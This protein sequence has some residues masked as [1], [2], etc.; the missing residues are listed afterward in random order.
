MTKIGLEEREAGRGGRPRAGKDPCGS[1]AET[2]IIEIIREFSRCCRVGRGRKLGNLAEEWEKDND[3]AK[4]CGLIH[5]SSCHLAVA[6]G[7]FDCVR[8]FS[9][10]L[11]VA[12]VCGLML[13]AAAAFA[14]DSLNWRAKQNQVDADI[15]SWDLNTLLKKIARQTGWKVYVER[16][17]D[18]AVSVKFKNL[19]EDQALRRL[20]GKLNYAKD[21][22]N[23]VARLLIFRTA[24]K[25]ATEA[26]PAEKKDYRIA[27]QDLVKLKHGATNSIDDLAKK[28]GAKVIGRNDRL[29]LYQLQFD[30]A[31]SA[32]AGLQTLAS[33]P[34][35]AA[36]DS[37]YLV[38]RPT[39]AQMTPVPNSSAPSFNLTAQP[40][41]DGQI[42]GLVDTSVEPP[43][44]YSK[45][46]LTPI[47]EAGDQ[48]DPSATPTH[49]T[50]M[51]ET[52]IDSMGNYPS[53][54]QPVDVYGQ[55]EATT[56]FNVISGIVDAIQA[57]ANP[58][59]LSL[60]GTGDSAMLG[61]VIQEGEQKGVV[62]VAAAG[63]TPGEG[64]VYPASYP[65]VISVTASTQVLNG[66][67]TTT[68]NA[69]DA[70]Q[71]ASYA[72]D[73]PG[74]QVI[75]P[76]TSLVQWNGQMWEVEGTSPAT[77]STSATI[78]E[79]MNQD[80]ISIEQAVGIVTR[81]APAPS[82]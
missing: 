18:S 34:S 16:G 8:R 35:V 81:V 44:Q 3:V 50:S 40:V 46:M 64:D 77:A 65:G 48:E 43:S 33:D 29:G 71:L 69:S 31:A 32:T 12:A 80:H 37:N 55:G 59:N 70:T 58:I 13:T 24:A 79:L 78:V 52:M 9:K 73:P 82:K 68:A 76:G 23:G 45:Y 25:A 60:G 57:G 10:I 61:E 72:N 1:G 22:S 27:D 36:A 41:A 28:V 6:C 66:P 17:A 74:T 30:D 38:D 11:S 53:R 62:F 20:L 5:H 51:L 4:D 49:G 47:N 21:Q 7:I 39:P 67:I 19:P 14:A 75:A 26:V 15:Q 56:T 63:N 54:I 42:I 2:G